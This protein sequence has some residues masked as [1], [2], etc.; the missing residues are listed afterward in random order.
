MAKTMRSGMALL[1]SLLLLLPLA[2]CGKPANP[3]SSQAGDQ[4]GESPSSAAGAPES[5]DFT[6]SGADS[7]TGTESGAGQETTRRPQNNSAG[8]KPGATTTTTRRTASS[9]TDPASY[10]IVQGAKATRVEQ[11][12]AKELQ[13][14]LKKITGVQLSIVNDSTAETA[15]EFIVGSTSRSVKVDKSKLK[16]DGFAVLKK[17]NK[18]AV[19]G[20]DD[21]STLYGVYHLLETYFGCGFYSEN[22]ESVPASKTI[23]LP[24]SINDVQNPALEYRDVGWHATLDT[25]F[26]AKMRNNSDHSRRVSSS[27]GR[28]I[29]YAGGQFVHTFSSLLPANKYYNAHPEYFGLTVSGGRDTATLCQ[30]NPEVDK[31]LTQSTLDLL[32]KDPDSDIVSVSQNDTTAYCRCEK[33]AAIIKEEGSPAGPIIRAINQIAAEV[34]KKYPH[35]QVDTLAYMYSQPPCKTKPADNVIVRL[36]SFY[37]AFDTPLNDDERTVNRTFANDLKGWGKLTKNIYVWDYTTDFDFYLYTYPNFSV[38]QPNIQFLI[39]NNVTGIFEQGN[40]NKGGEFGELR[41][42]LLSKLLWNPKADVNALMDGFLQ[43]YYGSGW[44]NI[45]TY[46]TEFEK[47]VKKLGTSATIYISPEILT[48]FGN[49]NTKDFVARAQGWWDAAEKAASGDQLEHVKRS[50]LQY[51]YLA[52]SV[53]YRSQKNTAAWKKANQQLLDDIKKYNIQLREHEEGSINNV[54]V[55]TPP[56]DWLDT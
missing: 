52:Q 15:N 22:F 23:R 5:G 34:K 8:Q 54:D 11:Q 36:C 1:L 27:Y 55:N 38:L 33:C 18:I 25:V 26:A 29:H 45:K 4:S 44:K 13:S 37:C 6:V 10:V 12:A 51:T 20:V 40:P 3:G 7:S 28:G 50:R 30:S 41:A 39:E 31:V 14:Y 56:I 2:A 24:D 49:A 19:E 48:P 43:A 17:G 16:Y 9:S 32:S 35:V 21:R 53:N 42:Y 46:I 47:L